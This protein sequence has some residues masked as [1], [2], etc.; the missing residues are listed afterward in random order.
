MHHRGGTSC[1]EQQQD[2][3]GRYEYIGARRGEQ[4]LVGDDRCIPLGS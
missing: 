4:I 3:E 2:G 1:D